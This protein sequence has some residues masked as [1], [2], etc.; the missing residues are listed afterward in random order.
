MRM[1]TDKKNVKH[2]K[3]IDRDKMEGKKKKRLFLLTAALFLLALF[4]Y[5]YIYL[6]V[7]SDCH[8]LL[9]LKT[10]MSVCLN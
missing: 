1:M 9:S 4:S 7:S 10:K 6:C 5:I 8:E 2:N 3:Q